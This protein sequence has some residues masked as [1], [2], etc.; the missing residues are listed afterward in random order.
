MTQLP[1][2][3]ASTR[4]ATGIIGHRAGAGEA[5]E[6]TVAGL[7]HCHKSGCVFAQVTYRSASLL[8]I[9]A[10]NKIGIVDRRFDNT[11]EQEAPKAVVFAAL[12]I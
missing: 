5:P 2:M 6:N 12:Y 7:R 4:D 10:N 1:G 3:F 9:R 11:D 8:L